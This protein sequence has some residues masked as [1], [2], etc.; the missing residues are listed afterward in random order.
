MMH[1]NTIDKIFIILV[2]WEFF[3]YRTL[4]KQADIYLLDDP[5]SAVDPNVGSHLFEVCIKGNYAKKIFTKYHS[6][7][8]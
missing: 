8:I 2:R 4:Y 5:L 1:I 7:L 3:S 6:T